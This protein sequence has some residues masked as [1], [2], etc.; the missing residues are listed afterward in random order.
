MNKEKTKIM[1][2]NSKNSLITLQREVLDEVQ[3][4]TY[5]GSIMDTNGGTDS[6]VRAAFIVLHTMCKCREMS[7]PT[8][9]HIFNSNVKVVLMYGSETW[10]TTT[11]MLQKIQ[12]FVNKL[13]RKIVRI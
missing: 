6:D 8:K 3:P 5:L 10:R 1:T 9:L 13:L 2:I 4:F 11:S 7:I 12:T